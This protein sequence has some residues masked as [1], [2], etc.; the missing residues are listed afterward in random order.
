MDPYEAIAA[1]YEAEHERLEAD[2]AFFD[3]L[4]EG[5]HLLVLG[6][7]T[8]RYGR[9]LGYSHKVTGLDRCEPMLAIARQKAPM[10]TY[11][12]GDMRDFDLGRFDE[13]VVPNG[14]FNF[15]PTRADQVRCLECCHRALRPGAALTLDLP[16]PDFR[17]LGTSHTP[18]K[19]AFETEFDGGL[20]RR[21][22]EVQRAPVS[23]RLELL[24]RY[25]LDGKLVATAPLVLRLVYPAEAEWMM[26]SV[27]FCVDALY[28]D[29]AGRPLSETS[30]RLIV[31]AVRL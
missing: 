7:G 29:Y 10:A 11:V 13:I 27:G 5:G 8:G 15:L 2:V 26:E 14:G 20:L 18:E 17:L 24:D 3:R 12:R 4:S 6:C 9:V 16:M 30:P 25:Y 21:T 22:R 1:F 28:G 31:R 23:Q 19:V